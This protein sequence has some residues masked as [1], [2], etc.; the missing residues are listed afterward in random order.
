MKNLFRKF[1]EWL[2]I[3]YVIAHEVE[4]AMYI[5]KDFREDELEITFAADEEM[6]AMIEASRPGRTK[7]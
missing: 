2:Y 4:K 3:R 7:H 6:E 5:V 1:I